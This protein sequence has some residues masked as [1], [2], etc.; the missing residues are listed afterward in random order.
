MNHPLHIA[1]VKMDALAVPI[2][3]DLVVLRLSDLEDAYALLDHLYA[4]F[5]P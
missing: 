3:K 5:V 2:Q 1:G 4:Q